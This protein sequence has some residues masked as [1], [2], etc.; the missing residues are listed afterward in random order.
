MS[1]HALSDMSSYSPSFN[2]T[3]PTSPDDIPSLIHSRGPSLHRFGDDEVQDLICVGFGPASLAIAVALHDSLESRET[4]LSARAPRVRFLEK[5]HKFAWHAG[6]LL[7]GAKMQITFIKDMATLRNPTS[8]FTFLNYLHEKDRLVAFTNL[9]TF[10]PLRAEY[11][12]Y[13]RWCAERFNNVVDYSQTVESVEAGKLNPNTGAVEYFHVVSTD[14]RTQEQTILKAKHVVIAAGGRPNI[15]KSLPEKHPRIIHSSQY[16]THV[17]K[18]FPEGTRPRR[19]AVIGGGQ[20]AAECWHDV[21]S[22][23]PGSQ[24]VLLIR[25]AALKPSDDSPFVNEVFNPDRVDDVFSQDPKVRAAM[26]ALDK[27]TNYGVVRI[28]LL[29]QIYGEMYS[30]QLQ[31]QSEEDWPHRIQKFREVTGMRD[32]MDNGRP[33]V[34]LQIQNN[35]GQYCANK[36]ICRESMVVDLVVVASGYKRDS[37]EEMLF[38]LRELMPGGGKVQGQKWSVKRDYA[39]EFAPGS[40]QC[41]AG[42]W[43][44]GCNEKTHGLSDTLLSILAVRG[45]E[46]VDNIFG[47]S[48]EAQAKHM[49]TSLELTS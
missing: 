12:D 40:V 1:P 22:R 2:S 10:L 42:V 25:G 11:E 18:I 41:D 15:P 17:H 16:A 36:E 23:F 20:S 5:Q 19:I 43:L 7:P 29:E 49:E 33:A 38:G 14:S 34:E 46:M 39:V 28:E 8:E 13:M 45:G 27:A 24:S 3:V 4:R 35:S 32:V 26:L 48:L 30:Y 31:H 47:Y 44:Q 37:H 6:M 9:G 21:P